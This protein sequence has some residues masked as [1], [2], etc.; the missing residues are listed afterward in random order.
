MSLSEE[1]ELE[2]AAMGLSLEDRD[3]E[4]VFELW[5]ENR[6]RRDALRAQLLE[7]EAEPFETP[8]PRAASAPVPFE[9]PAPSGDEL[10]WKS[11]A[12]LSGLLAR[13]EVS[14]SE[15]TEACLARIELYDRALAAFELTRPES[16]MRAARAADQAF[17]R[18]DVAGPLQGI[19]VACKSFVAARGLP[20]T[21]GASSRAHVIAGHDA[22]LLRNLKSAG[23]IHF[24]QVRTHEFGAGMAT[25]DGPRATGRNPWNLDR[26][27]GGSSSGSA[28]AVASGMVPGAVGTDSAGSVR[29]PA[30]NC[31]LVGL[32]PTFGLVPTGGVHPYAWSLDTMGTLTRTVT[33]A[34]LYLEGMLGPGCG[35]RYAATLNTSL[36]GRIIGVP[37]RYLWE[38]DDIRADVRADCEAALETLA[39]SGATL[40][41]VRIRGIE[42][43]DAIYTTLISEVYSIHR[44]GIR[45]NPDYC[46]DWF[47]ANTLAGA[48]FTAEDVHRA[49]RV[50][51]SLAAEFARVFDE[52]EV[53]VLPGQA[54][55]ATPFSNS[56]A[57]ALTQPRSQFMR[58]FNVT[59]LPAISVPCGFSEEGLPLAINFAGPAY[60]EITVMSVAH[61]FERET[62]FGRLRPDESAWVT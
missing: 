50:R 17:A 20:H 40:R 1:F 55:P 44:D 10:H 9:A 32:K 36:K 29:M 31:N 6:P 39:A 14:A 52:V 34:A 21:A 61:G 16:A 60:G 43:N 4:L 49:H 24:G 35:G 26:I 59:G 13:R 42:W 47:R 3:R 11:A 53:L 41:D 22:V 45:R 48:L 28:V 19:P 5:A 7:P 56:F 8:G 51:R 15:L 38:R 37:R 27:P 58:P 62:G 30:A 25:R 46:G 54:E 2:C 33:D 18:G 23:A 12:E 57:K